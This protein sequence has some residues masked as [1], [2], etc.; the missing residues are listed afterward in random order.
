[1]SHLLDIKRDVTMFRPLINIFFVCKIRLILLWFSRKFDIG[2]LFC[3]LLK[4]RIVF[5]IL[6]H[7]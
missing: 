6:I 3:C 7:P 2:W 1:M 4:S 5:N